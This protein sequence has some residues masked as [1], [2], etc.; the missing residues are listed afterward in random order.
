MKGV[1]KTLIDVDEVPL[2]ASA[3]R[4]T[5]LAACL[6]HNNV[7]RLYLNCLLMMTYTHMFAANVISRM[8]FALSIIM[9][10]LTHCRIPNTSKH[11]LTVVGSSPNTNISMIK[12]NMTVVLKVFFWSVVLP[13]F[14]RFHLTVY[15]QYVIQN[16]TMADV[17]SWFIK[18]LINPR[19]WSISRNFSYGTG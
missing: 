13:N 7:L 16:T 3:F 2:W 11:N 18:N 17:A 15:R 5:A 8:M 12:T 19:T 14:I 10:L 6:Q 9:C 1:Y 4:D